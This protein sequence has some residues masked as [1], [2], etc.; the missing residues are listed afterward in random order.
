MKDKY[1]LDTNF[2]VYLQNH[3]EPEKQIHC[4]TLLGKLASQNRFVI[5]TQVIQEF[6]VV[7][8]RKLSANPVKVKAV[9]LKFL[10]FEI[11]TVEVETVLRAMDLS[12]LN[13]IS[14]WDALIFSTAQQAGCTAVLTEDLNPGQVIGGVRVI[15]PFHFKL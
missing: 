15:N 7:M 12:I 9:A 3:L 5:S 8:T 10:A 13:Q 6:Y 2:L 14:L 11:S 1:F 4:R